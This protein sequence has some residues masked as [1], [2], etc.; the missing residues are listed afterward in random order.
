[1]VWTRISQ[2]LPRRAPVTSGVPSDSEAMVAAAR[3]G[4][5]SA[6]TWRLTRASSVTGRPANGLSGGNGASARGSDQDRAP[7]RMRSPARSRTGTRS[8][9]LG[10]ELG[11]GEAQ[12][13]A[14]LLE[15]FVDPG[16]L[17]GVEAGRIGHDQ[18][19]QGLAQQLE[20]AAPSRTSANGRQRTLDEVELGQ[21]RLIA[22]A[23][24]GADEA[25]AAPA[26]ALVEQEDAGDALAAG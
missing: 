12:Q 19:R 20:A 22:G 15:P 21:Q 7:P 5:G 2:P 10:G 26:P 17:L 1:M 9:L 14:A 25:D 16:A 13:H 18:Q 6:S 8:S 11:A 23:A 4:P 3:S 24:G